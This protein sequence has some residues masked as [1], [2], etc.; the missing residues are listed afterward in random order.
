MRGPRSATPV[1]GAAT[2]IRA[3][4]SS[5]SKMTRDGSS[6]TDDGDEI[7]GVAAVVVEMLAHERRQQ[8][9]AE[10]VRIEP[11]DGEAEQ[12]ARRAAPSECRRPA[13]RR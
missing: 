8:L 9:V 3:A 2:A 7:V 5:D 4:P 6:R 11:E 1:S 12:P 10:R 13:R